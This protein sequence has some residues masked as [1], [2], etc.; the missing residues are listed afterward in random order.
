MKTGNIFIRNPYLAMVIAIVI[1]LCGVL[2]LLQMPLSQY[3]NV[4]PPQITVSVT[5][6]GADAQ[7]LLESVIVPLEKQINGAPDLLYLN[8]VA[9]NSG[10][11]IITATFKLGSIPE[12]NQQ[13]VQDRVDW[14]NAQLPEAVQ[15]EGV[16]VR[17]QSGNILLGISLYSQ[18]DTYDTLFMSNYASIN[19]VDSLARI[20]GVA[21]V[22]LFGGSDYAMRIWV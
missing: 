17:Q 9:A 3:P 18:D 5:Y 8:S 16:I 22:E 19:L 6:P 20:P 1:V 4:T 11:A 15:K 2:A 13:N 7:T 21:Q 10:T 14:A 12:I